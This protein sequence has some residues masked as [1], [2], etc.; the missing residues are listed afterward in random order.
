M[1]ADSKQVTLLSVELVRH[2]CWLRLDPAAT[3]QCSFPTVS[4]TGYSAFCPITLIQQ[5]AI[6]VAAR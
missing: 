6:G 1:A 5:S 4:L 2:V 3:V